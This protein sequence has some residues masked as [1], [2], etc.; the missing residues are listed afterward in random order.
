MRTFYTF[1]FIVSIISVA[2]AGVTFAGGTAA[3]LGSL[4]FPPG[5]QNMQPHRITLDP[6]EDTV[7]ATPQVT[8]NPALFL[9]DDATGK[10]LAKIQET[11][12]DLN[13]NESAPSVTFTQYVHTGLVIPAQGATVNGGVITGDAMVAGVPVHVVIDE[14]VSPALVTVSLL[15]AT[16]PPAPVYPQSHYAPFFSGDVLYAVEPNA[17]ATGTFQIHIW[18]RYQDGWTSGR[19]TAPA[20]PSNV[21]HLVISEVQV[22]GDS[23]DDDFIELYNPTDAPVNLLGYRLVKRAGMSTTDTSIK[24]WSATTTIPAHGFYLWANSSYV[25]IP[26]EPDATTTATLSPSNNGVALRYGPANT[27]AIIDSVAWGQNSFGEGTLLTSNLPAGTSYE[28]KLW[29]GIAC[30]SAQGVGEELGNGCDTNNNDTD[31]NVR[32]PSTPQNSLSTPE[33]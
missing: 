27:G 31:F 23:T 8:G 29:Q 30:F 1:I 28:R 19:Y 18:L 16:L 4:L 15:G 5:T 22:R 10:G 17:P 20:I 32:S 25:S 11:L 26:V 7:T 33:P 21:S 3:D 6:I 24:S 2:L 13:V 14:T 9:Y 12:F